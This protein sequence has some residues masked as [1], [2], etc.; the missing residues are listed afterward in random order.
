MVCGG[1][2]GP[3]LQPAA[4]VG[5]RRKGNGQR[6]AIVDGCDVGG[7]DDARQPQG[8]FEHG[9][10]IT[11]AGPRAAAEW[12]VLPSI[13]TGR[14]FRGVLVF[15]SGCLLPAGTVVDAVDRPGHDDLRWWARRDSVS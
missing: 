14:V 10:V 12:Q 5:R 2:C 3:V 11:D 7:S 9:E 4:V 15:G 6:K 13:P 8:G 1:K